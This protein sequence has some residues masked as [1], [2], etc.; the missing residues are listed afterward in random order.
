MSAGTLWLYPRRPPVLC[1]SAP[2]E[3]APVHQRALGRITQAVGGD[4]NGRR[5]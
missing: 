2:W 4:E 3:R 5:A 1:D